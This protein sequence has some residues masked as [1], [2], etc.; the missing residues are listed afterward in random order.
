M[1][2][3]VLTLQR[4]KRGKVIEMLEKL[5]ERFRKAGVDPDYLWDAVDINQEAACM[6]F[7]LRQLLDPVNNGTIKYR[8]TLEAAM[9]ET[10]EEFELEE[11]FEQAF[12]I[13]AYR[14]AYD[15]DKPPAG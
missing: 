8:N 7:T 5:E 14:L 15:S 2:Y 13:T 12:V 10:D 9:D 1:D 3:M 4:E 6:M 11:G